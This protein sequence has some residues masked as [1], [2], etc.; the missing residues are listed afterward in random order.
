MPDANILIA[1]FF[2]QEGYALPQLVGE[3]RIRVV[4][5]DYVVKEA[6]RMVRNAFPGRQSELDELLQS[7]DAEW[8]P[9]PSPEDL[10]RYGFLVRDP[11]DHPVLVAALLADVDFLLTS[12]RALRA[13]A[14]ESLA[15]RG[16][17]LQVGTLG[18]LR[19]SCAEPHFP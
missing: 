16:K 1:F 8:V 2:R 5:C 18:E 13:D 15:A 3:G 10:A 6:R 17:S 14:A 7:L 4:L 11:A 12:D 19:R 9:A